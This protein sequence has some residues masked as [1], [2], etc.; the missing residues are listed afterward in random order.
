MPKK[1]TVAIAHSG[2]DLGTPAEFSKE[3]LAIVVADC[4]E[5]VLDRFPHAQYW[6][7]CQEYPSCT[8]IWANRPD[9]G[10]ANYVRNQAAVQQANR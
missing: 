5:P 7:E 6:G 1:T 3:Q 8:P 4:A 9:A 2:S 10:I